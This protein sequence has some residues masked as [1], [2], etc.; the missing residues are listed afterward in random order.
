MTSKVVLVMSL[1]IVGAGAVAI[2]AD[3]KAPRTAPEMTSQELAQWIDDR[4][5]LLWDE[6]TL[7]KLS[8]V[9]DTTF[10]RRVYLDLVGSI[11]TIS[12]IRDFDEA[13]GTYKRAELVN[14]LLSDDTRPDR[15]ATNS[16]QHLARIWRR[17]MIP[18]SSTNAAMAEQFDPWLAEQFA[19]NVSYDQFARSVVTATMPAAPEQ[20]GPPPSLAGT[21]AVFAQAVGQTPV[22]M[23]N[24]V[25]RYF[26]GVRIG[27]AQCHD[28]PFNSDL[29]Q[30]DF[31]GMAA[32]FSGQDAGKLPTIN[33]EAGKSY[34]ARFLWDG[35][36][37]TVE[38]KT[39]RQLLAD[40]MVSPENPNFSATAVNRI[41][42]HLCGRGLVGSVDDLDQV[43]DEERAVLDELGGLFAEAG[44]NVRWLMEGIC[45]SEFYQRASLA[46]GQEAEAE[47]VAWLRP[48]KT[49]TP[50]QVFD[51][52]EQ[53]LSLPI[54]EVDNPPRFNGLRNA[55]VARM[56]EAASSSP[57]DFRA[58]IPQALMIMNGKLTADATDLR[59]SR[60]LR[61]IVDAP[62]LNQGQKI[63][64]L[65]L[66]T[67]TR[68]PRAEEVKF[69]LGHIDD[70]P[71]PEKKRKAY[72]EIY[73]GLLNSPEFVLSR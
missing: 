63:E 11:P 37:E 60:T 1:I 56:D 5:R 28:H 43:S 24:A 38:D 51:S 53:A 64:A 4:L 41:W 12:Q 34:S 62:F 21:P 6:E 30:P 49:L 52:L 3:D 70:Q 2:K 29:T 39:P 7:E 22:S 35:K 69:L 13:E 8:V 73:W 40:W 46:R 42:Q 48:L 31:W 55:F 36:P 17:A 44:Y 18:K 57:E 61:A 16:S 68:R 66:A 9:D 26:L 19:K 14:K 50:E 59:K 72:E 23:A 71:T 27:C 10:I 25:T 67:F 45:K 20:P 54:G 58:G 32:F 65:Y 47:D 33:D 15:Y